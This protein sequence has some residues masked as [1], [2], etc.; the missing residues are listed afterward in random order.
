[1][2]TSAGGPTIPLD[3][4]YHTTNTFT[5]QVTAK[6][7]KGVVSE[8]ATQSVKISTVAM[9][10]DGWGTALAV[11]GN[12][13]GG[14]TILVTGTNTSGTAVSVTLNKASLGTFTPTGHIFVFGQ[15]GKDTITLQ[16]YVVGKTKYDIKVPALLYGEG[17]GGDHIS[18]AGSAANNVLTGHGANEILTGGQGRDL[19][20]AGTGPTTLN[21][22]VGDDI[23]IGGSTNYDIGS[24]SG[25]TY[26]RQWVALEAV[27]AE[28][29]STDSYSKRLSVLAGY[30]NTST[31]HDNYSNSRPLADQLLGNAADNDWFFA[32]VN[33]VVKGKSKTATVTAIH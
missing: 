29:G 10:S 9:E 31:V 6:D 23:L 30:L 14:D 7:Q 28:W 4:L 16:P 12:A 26:D 11:G 5:I 15:G 24:S 19:L 8:L 27:M 13:A 33:D 18:A 21:G 17:T 22:G 32:G 25:M 2:T 1:V 3:H 20:I